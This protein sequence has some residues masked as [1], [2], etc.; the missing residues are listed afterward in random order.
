MFA[1][2][3]VLEWREGFD[4]IFCCQSFCATS[5]SLKSWTRFKIASEFRIYVQSAFRIDGEA[6]RRQETESLRRIGDS[7][8]KVVVVGGDSDLWTDEDGIAYVGV[9]PFLSDERILSNVMS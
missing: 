1:L 4:A 6:K 5:K 3:A 2:K 7:F 8:R 9:I